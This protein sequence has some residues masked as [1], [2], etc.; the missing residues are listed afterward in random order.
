MM[1]KSY[2]LPPIIWLKVTDYMHAWTQGELGCGA[3]IKSTRVLCVQHLEGAREVLKMETVNDMELKPEKILNTM[4]A[5]RKNMLEAGLE[6]DEPYIEKAY[7][8]TKAMMKLFV[9]IECPKMC[10]TKDGVLRPW[11]LDVSLGREQAIAL[12]RLVRNA[13]WQAVEDFNTAY[14]RKMETTK[15]ADVD[16]I[17]DFCADTRTPDEYA[18]AIRREWQRRV[19]RGDNKRVKPEAVMSQ[20]VSL[21]DV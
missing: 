21:L 20:R 19:A 13:F 2:Q 15:Y 14:A 6:L 17:E 10:L 16:M 4:S 18:D 8:M 11:S 3:R 12:Q 9:P 5:N 1:E 7:G